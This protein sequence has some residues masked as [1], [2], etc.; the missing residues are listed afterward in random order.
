MLSLPLASISVQFKSAERGIG[1]SDGF[2]QI[3]ISGARPRL[4]AMNVSLLGSR[5]LQ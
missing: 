4:T 5:V 2:R 1:R 3:D